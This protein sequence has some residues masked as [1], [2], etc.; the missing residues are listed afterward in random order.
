MNFLELELQLG[1]PFLIKWRLRYD[2]SIIMFFFENCRVA[3]DSWN[4]FDTYFIKKPS[5]RHFWIV[6]CIFKIWI[7]INLYFQLKIWFWSNNNMQNL[8][9]K[10]RKSIKTHFFLKKINYSLEYLLCFFWKMHS[11]TWRY[12]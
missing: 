3:T 11:K 6:S 12:C 5:R 9:S 8:I 4:T 1:H 10:V 7:K 2:T